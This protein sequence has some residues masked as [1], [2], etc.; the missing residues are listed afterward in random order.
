MPKRVL[1]LIGI[2]NFNYHNPKSA[3]LSYLKQIEQAFEAEGHE[4]VLDFRNKPNVNEDH[5]VA[6]KK[7]SVSQHIKDIVK[8]WPWFYHSLVMTKYLKS[9]NELYEELATLEPFDLIVEFHTVGS[10]IGVRLSELWSASLSVIFDSPVDEQF[11]EMY[12]TKTWNWNSIIESEKKTLQSADKI[13]YYS[14]PCQKY[15]EKKYDIKGQVNILPCVLTKENH[16]ER[17]SSDLFYIGFIGSFLSWHKLDLLVQAFEEFYRRH[18]DA[19]L[20]LVGYGEEWNKIKKMVSS[21]DASSAIEMTGFVNEEE[22]NHYKS[23]FTIATMPGSNWYGSPLKLFE[24]AQASIPFI[25]PVSDTVS[26]IFEPNKHCLF[27]EREDEK[28]SLLDALE[29][30][31]SKGE[32]REL[33]GKSA[34][35]MVKDNYNKKTYQEKLINCLA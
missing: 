23:I 28:G 6:I 29:T 17:V 15:I 33:M 13:M 12:G 8:L 26:D 20:I 18:N 34:N 35:Q 14:R 16:V 22:L 3:V 30:M 32:K 7:K 9:Q 25:S 31:Y 10:T 4:V 5:S 19:R 1:I 24:Y 2:P 11:I 21:S 27:V